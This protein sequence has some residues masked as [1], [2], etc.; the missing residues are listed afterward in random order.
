MQSYLRYAYKFLIYCSILCL[1]FILAGCGTFQVA[2]Q[3]E[4][5]ELIA[6]SS[7]PFRQPDV[8]L[9]DLDGPVTPMLA[10]AIYRYCMVSSEEYSSHYLT[11]ITSDNLVYYLHIKD[12]K[13]NDKAM[14][15]VRKEDGRIYDQICGFWVRKGYVNMSGTNL[16]AMFKVGTNIEEVYKILGAPAKIDWC[17]ETVGLGADDVTL[18]SYLTRTGWS[19]LAFKNNKLILT[20]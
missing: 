18:L 1:L 14:L 5:H 17:E 7:L 8:L 6:R 2:D 9:L 11:R 13:D 10:V 3:M 4:V 20:E 19:A 16:Q 15:C 12:R